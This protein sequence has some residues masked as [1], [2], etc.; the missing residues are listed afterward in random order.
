M[1]SSR[2]NS[3]SQTPQLSQVCNSCSSRRLGLWDDDCSFC[4][5]FEMK[6]P[7]R[8]SVL[9]LLRHRHLNP[10]LRIYKPMALIQMFPQTAALHKRF[11]PQ[12]ICDI[13]SPFHYHRASTAALV[14][15][16][17]R[18]HVDDFKPDPLVPAF[19]DFYF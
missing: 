19:F 18:E 14:V 12:T 7:N 10:A 11:Q 15:W 17:C 16:V 4:R 13:S 9:M 6:P 8:R 5:P 3:T 2:Y 1:P